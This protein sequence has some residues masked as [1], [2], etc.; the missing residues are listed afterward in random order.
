MPKNPKVLIVFAGVVLAIMFVVT[1]VFPPNVRAY[2]LPG[3][4]V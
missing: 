3:P 1:N 2:F 4:T